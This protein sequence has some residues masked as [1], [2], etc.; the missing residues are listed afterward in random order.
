MSLIRLDSG[1]FQSNI[2]YY[3][4]KKTMNYIIAA[5]FTHLIQLV[6]KENKSWILLDIDV[7]NQR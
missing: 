7:M 6:V 4:P 5:K 3:L 1:F 2:L